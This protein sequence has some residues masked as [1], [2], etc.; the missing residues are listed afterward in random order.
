MLDRLDIHHT[1]NL[2]SILFLTKMSSENSNNSVVKSLIDSYSLCGDYRAIFE[3][4]GCKD[5]WSVSKIRLTIYNSFKDSVNSH[6]L[7]HI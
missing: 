3:H 6:T 4:Y 1:V 7:P 2:R 5:F